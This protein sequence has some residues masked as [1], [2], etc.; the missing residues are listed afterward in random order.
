M[1]RLQRVT[2]GW[3]TRITGWDSL[4]SQGRTEAVLLPLNSRMGQVLPP[5]PS[6]SI[7]C[8]SGPHCCRDFTAR[9]PRQLH[10]LSPTQLPKEEESPTEIRED[11]YVMSNFTVFKLMWPGGPILLGAR[12]SAFPLQIPLLDGTRNPRGP[13]RTQWAPLGFL[14]LLRRGIWGGNCHYQC[15]GPHPPQLSLLPLYVPRDRVREPSS[16]SCLPHCA[17]KLLHFPVL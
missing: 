9:P 11:A 4:L 14:D 5:L 16:I 15:K 3:P 7:S 10:F 8:R 17:Q 6:G 12:K 13:L 1:V 2:R